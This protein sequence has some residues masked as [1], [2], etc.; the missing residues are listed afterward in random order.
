MSTSSLLNPAP[1]TVR[2]YGP[3]LC[4]ALGA[5][6][7]ARDASV[8]YECRARVREPTDGEDAPASTLEV[9]VNAGTRALNQ[10]RE[11][12]VVVQAHCG[13]A[14]SLRMDIDA[15]LDECE[16]ALARESALLFDGDKA[17][18]APTSPVHRDDGWTTAGGVAGGL[19]AAPAADP[20]GGVVADDDY[21]EK[22]Q[23]A[24]LNQF[25]PLQDCLGSVVDDEQREAPV[26]E[27]IKAL[28]W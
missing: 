24:V 10:A 9:A 11:C 4:L 12:W 16:S 21:L 20:G 7:L 8:L 19:A 2:R 5:A 1:G 26:R 13:A 23:Q 18:P 14:V 28:H 27:R 25:G 15:T 17:P 22:W 3:A 6:K